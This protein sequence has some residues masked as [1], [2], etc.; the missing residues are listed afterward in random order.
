MENRL[1]AKELE[2]LLVVKEFSDYMREHPLED[3]YMDIG[4]MIDNN[5]FFEY[6]DL[7]D[8]YDTFSDLGYTD[9]DG[10]ITEKGNEY[11]AWVID[12]LNHKHLIFSKETLIKL[13]DNLVKIL[14]SK[15]FKAVA[16]LTAFAANAPRAI[17][18]IIDLIS[19]NIVK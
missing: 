13:R 12:Q 10:L 1:T 8:A 15:G 4:E 9:D 6:D 17:S 7:S 19:R 18:T 14:N 16:G 5:N 11:I 3:G 2:V